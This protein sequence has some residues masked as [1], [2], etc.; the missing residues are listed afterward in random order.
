MKKR[1][2]VIVGSLNMDIVVSTDRLPRSG[3]TLTG[4]SVHYIPG[5]KGA[6][7]AVCCAKLGADSTMIGLVGDDWFGTK[8]IDSLNANGVDTSYIQTLESASTG[9]ASITHMKEDNT[10]IVVPGTNGMLTE[11]E[12]QD[13]EQLIQED[14]ILLV[15]LE[16]PIQTVFT[17]LRM[18]K[19]IGAVTIL[20]PA[21]YTTLSDEL[22]EL[23]D[24]ITP[25]ET[26]FEQMIGRTFSG[27][28]SLE[29][30]I[31]DW[32]NQRSAMMIVTRGK[33][34]CSYFLH[35][36]VVTVTPPEVNVIDT[37]GAG[38]AFNG[39]LAY[40]LMSGWSISHCIE[41]A[42]QVS[43]AAV[44]RFGAQDGMPTQD[45]VL[46]IAVK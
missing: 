45:E 1:K 18:A 40:G 33:H 12:L 10:I 9:V 39:G 15:Q 16:I 30:A 7:Q 46:Q 41:F 2:I 4:H 24:Y 13:L 19:Q 3:E 6:N 43:A 32:Q 31:S 35:E 5:G 21:P 42:I 37:V 11:A 23:V 8:V 28:S 29:Q 26:E 22:L 20:N 34:G 17:A 36:D 14:D 44:T 38:D 25:N 27:E